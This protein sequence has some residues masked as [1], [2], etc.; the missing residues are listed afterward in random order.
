VAL[1]LDAR[2]APLAG[3][4][5]HIEPTAF[6]RVSALGIEE[7]RVNVLV[8]LLP[9]SPEEALG[10]GDGFRVDARIVLSRIEQALRVPSAA[11]VRDGQDW[12][13]WV[14]QNGRVQARK[15]LVID[16]NSEFGSIE[17]GP[18]NAGDPVV[19]YPAQLT[20][21]RRVKIP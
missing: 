2:Q 14:V 9:A 6:T 18:L 7:Q 12:R 10:L 15:V 4:V 1:S 13:V 20:E 8:D 16:R 21:G 19:L 11:L 17:P 5:R 3:R